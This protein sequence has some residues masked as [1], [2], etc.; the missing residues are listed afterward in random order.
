VQ[1]IRDIIKR[2][3][4][5][6]G[7]RL[8]PERELT[9]LLATSRTSIR[10]AL[11]TLEGLGIVKIRAGLGTFVRASMPT[12]LRESWWEEYLTNHRDR[13]LDML[14]V[15]EWLDGR[16]A[17]L[18]AKRASSDEINALERLLD[19]QARA[20][21]ANDIAALVETD[22]QFHNL[23]ARISRNAVIADLAKG[24][25]N[26][27]RDDRE[28]VF[29]LPGRPACSL[30]EHR[31]VLHAIRRGDAQGAE[32]LMWKHVQAVKGNVLVS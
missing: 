9:Q 26:A 24:I 7:E 27:L 23:I 1:S 22:V 18:A 21:E 4:L 25:I 13:V 8:P 15:R 20:V 14:E 17:A 32:Q 19:D 3:G 31:A 11:R 2:R 29:R 5:K 16:A 6:P 12:D 28:A 10:E 30:A